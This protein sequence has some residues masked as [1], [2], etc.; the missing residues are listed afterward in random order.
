MSFQKLGLDERL[1]KGVEAMGYVEPTPIQ[2]KSIPLAL[3]GKDIVGCAQTGTGK[4]AAFVLPILQRIQK[5][6]RIKAL[7]V[8]PTR[9]LA[10]QIEEV[11]RACSR[12]SGHSSLAVFGGVK[13][14]PQASRLK[15]GVDFLVAT[16]GRLLDLSRQGDV[17]L[18]GVEMLVLD[19]ADRMLDMGFWPDVRR[20]INLLPERR[21]NLLFSATMSHQVLG[22]IGST[23][24]HPERVDVAPASTPVDG[25]DQA[26]YPVNSSQK[27]ELLIELLSGGELD[28]VL[29]FTRTKHRADR[30]CRTLSRQGIKGAPI[31]SNRSQ[32][33][34]QEALDGFKKGK[35]SV[36]VATDIVARGIDVDN[37]SHVINFDM[38]TN[39]ED[40]VHRIGRTAR[41]G[42]TGTAISLLASEE[43]SDLRSIEGLIGTTLECKDLDGFTYMERIVPSEKR[44]AR[45]VRRLAY[46]GGARSGRRRSPKRRAVGAI[47]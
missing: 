12:F 23:L 18:G 5:G 45:K 28:R 20:I 41:A 15:R 42:C 24:N 43:T 14:G 32:S 17:D 9:E 27:S 7:V 26:V 1:L 39:P 34:R 44:E 11:A 30:L 16:P 22:V 19:E 46:N 35:Y 8:T 47:S 21:Q 40:Y 38:P 6:R 37:I 2:S 4:T 10:L 25:V 36:L 3:E 13:Y 31:H 29:I 33:Q